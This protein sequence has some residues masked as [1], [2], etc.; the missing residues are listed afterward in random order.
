VLIVAYCVLVFLQAWSMFWR[1]YLEFKEGEASEN[2]Y[3]DRDYLGDEAEEI[4]H[5]IHSGTT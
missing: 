5:A 4:E 3:L 1:S 2:K